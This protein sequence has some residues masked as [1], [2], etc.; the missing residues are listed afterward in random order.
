MA[1]SVV[2]VD[3]RHRS[4]TATLRGSD[5][6]AQLWRPIPF[7]DHPRLV[8][9]REGGTTARSLISLPFMRLQGQFRRPAS[10]YRGADARA[11]LSQLTS[12]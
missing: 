3:S 10:T 8:R 7:A 11:A 1:N 9:Y 5:D 2:N 4:R 6:R 12:A